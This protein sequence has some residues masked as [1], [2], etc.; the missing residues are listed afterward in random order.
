[1]V[2]KKVYSKPALGIETYE[3]SA[4]IAASCGNKVNLG[5]EAPGKDICGEYGGGNG[6]GFD[7]VSVYSMASTGTTPFYAD[8]TANCDCYYT[9]GGAGYFTS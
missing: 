4:D 6:G 3:M 9:S 5:P 1:M 7:V 8:G 2:M